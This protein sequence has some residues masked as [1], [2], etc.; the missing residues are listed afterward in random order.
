[1]GMKHELQT[2]SA[3]G[4]DAFDPEYAS[5]AIPDAERHFLLLTLA[6]ARQR[7]EEGQTFWGYALLIRG[8]IRAEKALLE[9][10]VWAGELMRYWRSAIRDYCARHDTGEAE[11]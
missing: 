2:E 10:H 6:D 4:A 5:A 7:A 1:M 8:L 11:E 9:E 3:A